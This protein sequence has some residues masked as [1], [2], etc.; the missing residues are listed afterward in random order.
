MDRSQ[1]CPCATLQFGVQRFKWRFLCFFEQKYCLYSLYRWFT[2]LLPFMLLYI[3]YNYIIE[4]AFTAFPVITHARHKMYTEHYLKWFIC[5]TWFTS[6]WNWLICKLVCLWL[7]LT[8]VQNCTIAFQN[9]MHQL[10]LDCAV[11]FA[12]RPVF[13]FLYLFTFM[14]SL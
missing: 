6:V 14:V 13:E 7:L 4:N 2:Y 9:D 1:G 11:T 3:I 10:T 8:T 12:A 5:V